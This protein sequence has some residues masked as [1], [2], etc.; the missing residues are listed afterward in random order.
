ML[1]YA[2]AGIGTSPRLSMELL[3]MQANINIV[4][5]RTKALDWRWWT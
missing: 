2:S 3:R 4:H 1:N 5:T